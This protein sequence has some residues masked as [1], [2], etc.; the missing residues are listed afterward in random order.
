MPMVSVPAIYDG[1]NIRLLEN[2]PVQEPYRVV[3]VLVEPTGEGT[4]S[5]EDL[6]RF[7]DSFGAWQDDCPAEATLRDIH[8]ARRSRSEPP[9]L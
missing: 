8:D 3:V 1:K 7:W 9:S 6:A 2:A 4:T 5:P